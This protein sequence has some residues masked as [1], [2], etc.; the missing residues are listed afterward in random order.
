VAKKI[1]AD[2]RGYL[3]K[4][5]KDWQKKRPPKEKLSRVCGFLSDELWFWVK[6]KDD[7]K[8]VAK[9]I[10]DKLDDFGELG[11]AQNY[12]DRMSQEEKRHMDLRSF[13]SKF[14]HSS[15]KAGSQL[16]IKV[17]YHDNRYGEI[18]SFKLDKLIAL[19][20]I[21]KFLRSE[22]WVTVG[23]DPIRGM[24]GS[25]DGPERRKPSTITFL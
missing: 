22:G 10:E 23:V 9:L 8:Q 1:R 24:G 2:L 12:I 15:Q 16:L 21:K 17:M 5:V 25:Y 20:K 6:E 7:P 19:R 4:L 3:T 18:E 11:M 14:H 13:L